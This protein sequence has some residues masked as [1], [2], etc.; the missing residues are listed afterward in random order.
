MDFF[1]RGVTKACLKVEGKVLSI[2]Q[3]LR[4]VVIGG[5][6]ASMQVFTSQVGSMSSEQVVLLDERIIFLTSSVVA[7]EKQLKAGGGTKG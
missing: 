3:R 5:S 4:S 2:R 6:S 1:K 7:G